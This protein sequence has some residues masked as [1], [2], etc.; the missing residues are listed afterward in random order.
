[1][2]LIADSQRA[3]SFTVERWT[4]SFQHNEITIGPIGE[5]FPLIG[6]LSQFPHLRRIAN[7]AV[8]VAGV[9]HD[10]VCV[11]RDTVL[12]TSHSPSVVTVVIRTFVMC[13][14]ASLA[15]RLRK[16]ISSSAAHLDPRTRCLPDEWM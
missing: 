11:V 15:G 1:M 2:T 4:F 3:V 13:E 9:D 10:E 16:A 7:V 8:A 5:Q 6:V 12:V 14:D